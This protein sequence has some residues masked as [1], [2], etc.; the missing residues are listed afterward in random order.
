M[1][2]VN[3]KLEYTDDD[4]KALEK[5]GFKVSIK[6]KGFL[7]EITVVGVG[8]MELMLLDDFAYYDVTAKEHV[9]VRNIPIDTQEKLDTVLN[10]MRLFL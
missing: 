5:E 9:F 4:L 3:G 8:Y 6:D 1:K 2:I 10:Y 7:C